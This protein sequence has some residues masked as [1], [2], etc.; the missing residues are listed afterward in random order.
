MVQDNHEA[1]IKPINKTVDEVCGCLHDDAQ[2]AV[3]VEDMNA[4][5]AKHVFD[6]AAAKLPFFDLLRP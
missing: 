5:I 6:K 3:S 1:L 2:D 4:A